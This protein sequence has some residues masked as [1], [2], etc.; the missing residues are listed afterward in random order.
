MTWAIWGLHLRMSVGW[1]IALAVSLISSTAIVLAFQFLWGSLAFWMP[2][3]A[4]EI[5]MSSS[6]IL[7]QLKPFPLD[8]LSSGLTI[9]LL[10]VIPSGFVAWYP[11]RT[12]LGLD[13]SPFSL[14]VTPLAAALF[15][16]L[17]GGVFLQ[18]LKA[19]VRRG[20][21]RYTDFGHRR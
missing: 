6:A 15:W 14:Y 16:V 20:S 10:T 12:L 5:S 1:L 18:G 2:Q 8:G 3:S 19:Y 7:D 17:A 13:P 9:G 11:C 4:E 21:Q